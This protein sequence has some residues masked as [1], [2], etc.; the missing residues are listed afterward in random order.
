MNS[1]V[2]A[3][4]F[5]LSRSPAESLLSASMDEE[6]EAGF[7]RQG[8]ATLDR[9]LR[10][11]ARRRDV[12][13]ADLATE[14]S[15]F[16]DAGGTDFTCTVTIRIKF[17]GV[18]LIR[19]SGYGYGTSARD[20]K[21]IALAESLERLGFCL[22]GWHDSTPPATGRP[23]LETS[24]AADNTNGACFHSSPLKALKGAFCELLERDAFLVAWYSGHPLPVSRISRGHRLYSWQRRFAS[25][26]WDLREHCW[27]HDRVP[28]TFVGLSLTR[29]TP[30]RDQWNFFF[31]SGAAPRMAEAQ[32]RALREMLKSRRYASGWTVGTSGRATSSQLRSPESRRILYQRP[33]FVRKF[34]AR[35]AVRPRMA[36]G[37]RREL[38]D[39][40]FV[41][42]CFEEITSA[43]VVPLLLPRPFRETAFCIQIVS[44]ELQMLDW[45]TPPNYNSG[46]I[47]ALC[48]T[49]PRLLCRL[50]HPLS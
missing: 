7:A 1:K 21:L 22:R 33:A 26:G 13:Y 8:F 4:L 15:R 10:S 12:D 24:A 9:F 35:L 29:R 16:K 38:S 23:L 11:L 20:A 28:A 17:R 37:L 49:P 48:R 39:R 25:E 30:A 41:A 31:G 2:G 43:K 36:V 18:P 47:Q 6:L 50:H 34:M 40:A 14:P 42:Q 19:L 32:D 3:P 46:R 44:D 5:Q 27:P 45:Q